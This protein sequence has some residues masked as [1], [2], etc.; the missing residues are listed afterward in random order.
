MKRTLWAMAV[1][2]AAGGA[3]ALADEKKPAA[4]DKP[5]QPQV[6]YFELQKAHEATK[7]A[8]AAVEQVKPFVIQAKVQT[9]EV[10]KEVE[11]LLKKLRE[12]EGEHQLRFKLSTQAQNSNQEV[13]AL[14]KQV[15]QKL[16]AQ[17]G[18]PGNRQPMVEW[19]K[20]ETARVQESPELDKARAEV[21]EAEARLAAARARLAKLQGA[22]PDAVR[23][24]RRIRIQQPM[25][26]P[27]ARWIELP[28]RPGVPAVPAP[29][30]KA[31]D[32][33]QRLDRLIREVDAIRNELKKGK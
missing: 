29:P 27:E 6:Y 28:V 19:K 24:E 13:I 33:E 31:S 32:L 22:V 18:Q 21:K 2:L 11:E 17:G 8:H 14:L 5:A 30:A 16:E 3:G 1:V 20:I 25:A 15:I 12:K 23:E 26:K 7:A 4:G 9:E 10:Q